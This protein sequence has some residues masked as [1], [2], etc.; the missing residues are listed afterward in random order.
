MNIATS[1]HCAVMF[2]CVDSEGAEPVHSD[3]RLRRQG[4]GGVHQ[5]GGGEAEDQG[6]TGTHPLRLF[7]RGQFPPHG[8]Q[9][10]LPRHLPLPPLTGTNQSSRK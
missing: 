5:E 3:Q 6:Q 2:V 10:P 1:E 7:L 9:T 8:Q 4:V